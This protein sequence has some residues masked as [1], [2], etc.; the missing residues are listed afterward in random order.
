[1]ATRGPEKTSPGPECTVHETGG[2]ARETKTFVIG[3]EGPRDH[4]E[5]QKRA[6]MEKGYHLVEVEHHCK[7]L[8][9]DDGIR[10]RTAQPQQH[11]CSRI[12]LVLGEK[13]WGGRRTSR[14]LIKG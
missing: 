7:V 5:G 12:R 4:G 14:G 10:H 6:V 13:S 11:R 3:T 9:G 2:A 1:M 8:G